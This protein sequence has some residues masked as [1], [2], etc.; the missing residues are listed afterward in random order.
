MVTSKFSLRRFFRN[1]S[2]A[3][4]FVY[5]L[6]L[7]ALV[8]FAGLG[9]EIGYWYVSK[10][11][12]QSAADAGAT[13]GAL[14]LT[15]GGD[16]NDIHAQALAEAVRNGFK[17]GPGASVDVD[18]PPLTGA[19][20]GDATAV[21]VV[22]G[23]RRST[24]FAAL[25]DDKEVEIRARAVARRVPG[26][27]A[28][29]L[30]LDQSAHDA[31]TNIGSATLNIDGCIVA[32]NSKQSDAISLGGSSILNADSLWTSGKIYEGSNA[33]VNIKTS[34]VE[35]GYPLDDPYAGTPIPA[36]TSPCIKANTIGGSMTI[37]NAGP[38]FPTTICSPGSTLHL[39]GSDDIDFQPG[40][41]VFNNVGLKVDAGASI[42]CSACSPGGE[43]V[44]FVFTGSSGNQV[45]TVDINGSATVRLNAPSEGTYAGMLFYQD[46]IAT[47]NSSHT[48]TI[49]GGANIAL[50]GALYFPSTEVGL[51]GDVTGTSECTL[52]VAA[53]VSFSGNSTLNTTK[54]KDYGYKTVTSVRVALVE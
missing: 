23:V 7:P 13:A 38:G 48:S 46:P 22:L 20:A 52:V 34:P 51:N 29:I 18:N 37:S 11:N 21:E 26:G 39:T 28:C 3:V 30:A 17:T 9:A 15:Y 1:T 5:A 47:N 24:M 44:T 2:G 10:R 50:T 36:T 12:I 33:T 32:S 19:F 43:G 27:D 14:E 41:Y 40:T 16:S 6:A 49:N 4:V 31:V 54:C 45:G 35:Q 25:V 8:G 42:T 53:T